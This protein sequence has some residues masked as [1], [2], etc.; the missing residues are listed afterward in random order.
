MAVVSMLCKEQG[1]TVV[2][3][4][5]AY[6]LIQGFQVHTQAAGTNTCTHT[7]THTESCM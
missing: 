5:V 2:T 6:E 4:C 3:V 1:I 7:H